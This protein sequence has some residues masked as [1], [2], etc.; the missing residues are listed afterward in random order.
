MPKE[1]TTLHSFSLLTVITVVEKVIAFLFEAIIA[2]TLGTNIITDGYFTS[3]ELFTLID[4]AFLSAIVVVALNRYTFH[5]TTESEERGFEVLSDLQ[6]FYFPFML[7]LTALVFLCARPLSYAVAPGYGEEARQV[8]V[9]CIRVMSV[10]PSVVCITSIGL[11]VLR[12]KKAFGITA[13]KSLFIS[14]VGIASVLIFGRRELKNADALSVAYVI[15]IVLYCLLVRLYSRKYGRFGFGLPKL[16]EDVK[17][18]LKMMFPL[19]ISYGIGRVALMVDKVIASTLGVGAVSALTYAHSLYK[20]V[21]AIF[22]TNLTTIILTDF[23][24]MCARKEYDKITASMRRTISIMTLVLIPITIVSVFCANDIVKIVY[25]RGKFS[26][27][28]T[29]MVG[30]VLLFYAINFVPV[31]IQGVY[32]QALY[33]FGDTLKPMIISLIAIVINLGTSIPLTFVIGLPGVAVGTVISTVIAVILERH[34]VK[35]YLPEYEGGYKMK[36]AVKYIISAA[37][38]AAAVFGITRLKLMPIL[39]FG[40]SAIAGFAAFGILL[41]ALREEYLMGVISAVK[42]KLLRK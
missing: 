33:A 3:A 19:M 10:I 20:V 18:A 40:V 36:S 32:I 2:A 25:E 28:A 27:D 29:A 9:R 23:N 15:S 1:K 5:A 22:V 12:Q 26:P 41:I 21:G 35:K 24:N 31:M 17:T 7:L 8:V 39:N 30:G 37:V 42:K 16:T 4:S 11:A 14:V 38:S 6:S 34:A 13:L